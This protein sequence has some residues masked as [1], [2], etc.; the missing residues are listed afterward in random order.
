MFKSILKNI[1]LINKIL[2]K[3][4]KLKDCLT[5]IEIGLLKDTVAN[6][7]SIAIATKHTA[8]SSKVLVCF[9]K[10]QKSFRE[11]NDKKFTFKATAK[12]RKLIR[13]HLPKR[14][15]IDRDHIVAAIPDPMIEEHPIVI[16]AIKHKMGQNSCD[17]SKYLSE[18]LDVFRQEKAAREAGGLPEVSKRS[19]SIS[20]TKK[21]DS[22]VSLANEYGDANYM[23]KSRS[24]E[25]IKYLEAPDF[26]PEGDVD[27]DLLK[28]WKSKQKAYPQLVELFKRVGCL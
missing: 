24:D 13:K 10:I 17:V 26:D 1:V 11:E 12:F 18:Q 5:P 14:F 22:L 16:D 23:N 3:H 9:H 15:V 28:Y 27:I 25:V 4:F 8:V 19:N 21:R 2:E 6:L 20:K 7:E